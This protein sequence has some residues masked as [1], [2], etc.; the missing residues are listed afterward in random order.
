[1]GN[2]PIEQQHRA[3]TTLLHFREAATSTHCKACGVKFNGDHRWTSMEDIWNASGR[4]RCVGIDGAKRIESVKFTAPAL[5]HATISDIGTNKGHGHAWTRPDGMK[6]RCGGPGMCKECARDA[7][8]VAAVG[9]LSK[10]TREEQEA[11]AKTAAMSADI[12]ALAHPAAEKPCVFAAIEALAQ[13]ARE[14]EGMKPKVSMSTM[15]R[16][17]ADPETCHAAIEALKE[18]VALKSLDDIYSQI[19]D[20]NGALWEMLWQAAWDRANDAIGHLL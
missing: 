12:A 9:P 8:M 11:A 7:A 6:A 1:M 18:L 16:I 13:Q 14:D 20:E 17:A 19:K 3:T 4:E 15:Q 2:V 10:K 5:E